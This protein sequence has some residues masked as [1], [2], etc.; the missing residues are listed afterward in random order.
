[1]ECVQV[2]SCVGTITI[3]YVCIKLALGFFI[4][5]NYFRNWVILT[6]YGCSEVARI[7]LQ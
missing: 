4:G 5:R 1:M 2:N 7:V 3:L 6:Q